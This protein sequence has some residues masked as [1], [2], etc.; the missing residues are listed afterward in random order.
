MSTGFVSAN[1]AERRRSGLGLS[2]SHL[3]RTI[4]GSLDI[5]LYGS[6]SESCGTKEPVSICLDSAR[7]F[8]S[9]R[10]QIIV[11]ASDQVS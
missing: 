9:V 6:S 4:R 11:T 8:R 2:G 7:L 10:L 1:W 5:A 3:G